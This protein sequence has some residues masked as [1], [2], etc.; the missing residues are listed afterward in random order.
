MAQLCVLREDLHLELAGIKEDVIRALDDI[1]D[2]FRWAYF[3]RNS[4]RTLFEIRSTVETLRLQKTFIKELG[5][6]EPFKAALDEFDNAMSDAYKLVK[7]LRHETG[8]HPKHAAF[9]Q[10]LRD[11]SFETQLL[12]QRGNTPKNVHYKF[13]LEFLA[14]IFVRE[15][16]EDFEEEWGRILRTTSDVSFKAVNALDLIFMAYV[17]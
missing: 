2:N 15:V 9:K 11:I 13:S 3:F 14:A 17:Q 10:A 6:L 16:D 1:G 8:G 5:K 7:R 4:T 12:F